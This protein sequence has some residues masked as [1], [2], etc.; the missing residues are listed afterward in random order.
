MNSQAHAYKK[1]SKDNKEETLV[2]SQTAKYKLKESTW[3]R[4]ALNEHR[5]DLD[6]AQSEMDAIKEYSENIRLVMRFPFPAGSPQERS[7]SQTTR[8]PWRMASRHGP[9]H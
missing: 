8:G 9:C 6:G 7:N 3:G 5:S 4:K 2:K 1:L